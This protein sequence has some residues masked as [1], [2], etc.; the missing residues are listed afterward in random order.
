M[1]RFQR[2]GE[3]HKTENYVRDCRHNERDTKQSNANIPDSRGKK[4]NR[5]IPRL[6]A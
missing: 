1:K 2:A 3:R 6:Q 4:L 5:V